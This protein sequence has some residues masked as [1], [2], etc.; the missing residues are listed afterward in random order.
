MNSRQG[1]GAFSIFSQNPIYGRSFRFSLDDMFNR[2]QKRLLVASTFTSGSFSA[3]QI[4]K[5]GTGNTSEVEL[6]I[7]WRCYPATPWH[8]MTI[9]V[10]CFYPAY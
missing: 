2:T 4:V 9:L 6:D 8:T 5:M 3:K 7:L 1:D 10:S